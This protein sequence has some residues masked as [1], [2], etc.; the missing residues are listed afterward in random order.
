MDLNQLLGIGLRYPHYA[1]VIEDRPSIGWFEVHSENFFHQGGPAINT[2]SLIREHY[3]ISLHGVGL[4]LGSD[5]NAA[6]K[7]HLT[8]LK[9][10]I[11][12]INPFLVSEHLSWSY[13][14]GVYLPDLLPIAYTKKSLD[15]FAKNINST[16]EFLKREILIENPSSYLEYNLTDMEEVDFLISLCNVTGAKILLDV[17]NIFVSCS[18]HNWNAKKYIDKI[19]TNLVKEIHLAGHSKKSMTNGE[20]VLIDTHDNIV[21]QEVWDLYEYAIQRFGPVH[22]L[23]EWDAKIPDFSILLSEAAKASSYLEKSK[24][25]YA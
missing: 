6:L 16:Q 11:D 23:L 8:S 1:K 13:I 18:N 3:P 4:S 19:P 10:L 22:T 12:D 15:L 2:L 5:N 21:C 17:N 9:E 7:N 24:R 20:V 25:L 14:N